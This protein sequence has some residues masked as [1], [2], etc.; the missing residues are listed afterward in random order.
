MVIVD[1]AQEEEEEEEEEV[2]VREEEGICWCPVGKM[3]L[4]EGHLGS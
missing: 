3:A 4:R 1:V 2:V